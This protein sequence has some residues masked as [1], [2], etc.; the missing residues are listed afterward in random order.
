MKK[1]LFSVLI[2]VCMILSSL[3]VVGSSAYGDLHD[4]RVFYN[5]N[6]GSVFM[7]AGDE[8]PAATAEYYYQS[9]DSMSYAESSGRIN[10]GTPACEQALL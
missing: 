5:D 3:P 8:M 9:G 7:S 1:R 4:M 6:D 10:I 2:C